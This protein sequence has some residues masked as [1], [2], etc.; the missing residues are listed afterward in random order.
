M[1]SELVVLVPVNQLALLCP[2]M[3]CQVGTYTCEQSGACP[4][5]YLMPALFGV[6]GPLVLG[7]LQ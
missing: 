5:A 7:L 6:V 3:M 4:T 2:Y 1:N